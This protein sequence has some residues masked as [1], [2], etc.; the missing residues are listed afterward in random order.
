MLTKPS[1]INKSESG[2][3]LILIVFA[4]IGLVAITGLVVDGGNAYARTRQAQAAA[5]A[6]ALGSG[7][8]RIRNNS[9]WV[10]VGYEIA[11]QNGF[12]NDGVENTVFISSPPASGLY[13]GNIEYIQV[14]ITERMPT[15]F[16]GVVGI[17][18]ITIH[19]EAIART[20]PS[21]IGQILDGNAVI[22][23]APNSD[24]NKNPALWVYGEATLAITGG[25][26]FVNSKDPACALKQNGSG[27]IRIDG[28]SYPISVVGGAQIQK[29]KLLTPFPPITGAQSI[30]YPPP[31][32]MPDINCGKEAKVSED[33]LTMTA[34]D[35]SDGDFPP[36]GVAFLESGAYCIHGDF[37]INGNANISGSNVTFFV[38][39]GRVVWNGSAHIDF[40][41]PKNGPSAGLLLYVP[42]ENKNNI[43][44]NGNIDSEITGTVLAPGAEIRLSGGESTHGFH[45]QF[46]GYTIEANGQSNTIIK[47][48]DE[49]NWDTFTMPEIQL[50][51]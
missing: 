16:G 14:V 1:K 40:K 17:S 18:E 3:A 48:N 51:K 24:C 44:I 42:I 35:W 41:A 11:E 20:K 23:L 43:F 4:I 39:N 12:N 27:S 5:D 32:Y 9:T 36:E 45:S 31:F 29:P 10:Q 8:A 38:P 50:A 33:G 6:A 25:G 13:V 19:G 15:F 47:Y 34:G 21:K 37:I 26:V 7:L 49:E 28:G 46:I 30:P 2:Q 22:S